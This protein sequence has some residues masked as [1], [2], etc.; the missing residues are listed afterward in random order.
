M[1][2]ISLIK[3]N[4]VKVEK[5]YDLAYILFYFFIFAQYLIK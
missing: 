3:I 5:N 1:I 4:G 2:L